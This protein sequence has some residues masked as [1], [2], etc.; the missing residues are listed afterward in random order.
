MAD[1]LT[2]AAR[3]L[4][5]GDRALALGAIAKITR[6]PVLTWSR[7]RSLPPGKRPSRRTGLGAGRVADLFGVEQRG[8]CSTR[9]CSCQHR[10]RRRQA[11][12]DHLVAELLPCTRR[13]VSAATA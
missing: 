11:L 12:G 9:R 1:E 5:A 10:R 8:S 4:R 13:S 6:L 3:T 7:R 2:E